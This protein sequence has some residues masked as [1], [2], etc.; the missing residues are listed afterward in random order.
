MQFGQK[1]RDAGRG[2]LLQW[3]QLELSFA[4]EVDGFAENPQ[5]FLRRV[6][7]RRIFCFDEIKIEL[8]LALEILRRGDLRRSCVGGALFLGR[9]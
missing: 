8:R 3:P 5:R 9:Q 4:R 6:E 2:V 1:V 7:A